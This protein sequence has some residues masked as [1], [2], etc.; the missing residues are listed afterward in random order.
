MPCIIIIADLGQPAESAKAVG[1]VIIH[2]TCI[3]LW[4]HNVLCSNISTTTY[5]HPHPSPYPHSPGYEQYLHW[6][7]RSLED[8]PLPHVTIYLDATPQCCY[9]RI[10]I[11]ARVSLFHWL[12]RLK[13][14]TDVAMSIYMLW[15]LKTWFSQSIFKTSVHVL[16]HGHWPF[17]ACHLMILPCL[18]FLRMWCM[19]N[20]NCY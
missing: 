8:L 12:S 5:F 2:S 4:N 7:K 3:L 20:S 17:S 9:D 6:R 18:P 15:S 11:R 19:Y 10:H 16:L 14:R 13:D 1:Q